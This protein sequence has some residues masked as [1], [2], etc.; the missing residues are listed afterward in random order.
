MATGIE[1]FSNPGDIGPIYPFP[2]TEVPLAIIGIVLWIVWH[3]LQNR[4]ESAEWTEAEEK[5]D[6]RLL[7]P[8]AGEPEH[9]HVPP[10]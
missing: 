4:Q 7:L 5:F 9:Q 10:R 3:V 6:E 1:S 8:G 2:G